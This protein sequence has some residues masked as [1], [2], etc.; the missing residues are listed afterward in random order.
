MALILFEMALASA[1]MA[2]SVT[3]CFRNIVSCVVGKSRRYGVLVVSG[4]WYASGSPEWIVPS[5]A[6]EWGVTLVSG[7]RLS[8]SSFDLPALS[9]LSAL[10]APAPKLSEG[11]SSFG[12]VSALSALF[13]HCF[14]TSCTF[15]PRSDVA[16]TWVLASRIAR[17]WAGVQVHYRERKPSQ[18]SRR[19]CRPHPHIGVR[20]MLGTDSKNAKPIDSHPF[21]CYRGSEGARRSPIHTVAREE[22]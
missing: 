4:C 17:G 18:V 12:A 19:W 2:L 11:R 5:P 20:D 22:A 21:P 9:A 6:S 7:R 14:C 1:E 8:K 16:R 13:L 10:S 3:L 15:C